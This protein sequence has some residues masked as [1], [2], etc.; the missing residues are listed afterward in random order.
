MNFRSGL[1]RDEFLRAGTILTVAGVLAGALGYVYQIVLVQMLPAAD[2][3]L[4]S[5]VMALFL[6]SSSPLSAISMIISKRVSTLLVLERLRE[7]STLFVNCYRYVFL[8]SLLFLFPLAIL[9]SDIQIYLKSPSIWPVFLYGVIVI[10]SAMITI[11]IAFLQAFKKFKTLGSMGVMGAVIKIIFSLVLV[12]LGLG[13]SGA[14]T[15]V[16]IASSI[17]W[18]F[19][20]YKIFEK[21]KALP[22]GDNQPQGAYEEKFLVRSFIPVLLANIAFAAMTQ[23]DMVLVNYFFDTDSSS[24]YAIASVLGKAILY[25]PSGM[26]FA[27]F[28][29]VAEN[30]ARKESSS[31]LFI[32]VMLATLLLCLTLS[33]I[34]F[35]FS[36][37]ILE[38]VFGIK[39]A[40]ASL[41]LRCFGFA[42]VPFA[43][44]LAAEHYLIAQGRVLFAWVFL[45][46]A[47]I[48]IVA[49]AHWHSDPLTVLG[50]VSATGVMTMIVGL[51]FLL[52]GYNVGLS[53]IPKRSN[54]K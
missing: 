51:F 49:I 40:E 25:I 43:V 42:M 15:G 30:V 10:L 46:L 34:Y 39:S 33:S 29:M 27:L 13:A 7:L 36:D 9:S 50:L 48:E 53:F 54:K 52:R 16:L 37:V 47:P 6:F 28:P 3:A 8:I 17:A 19:Y 22:I 38:V 44:T 14:I 18:V 26:V 5:A 32:K 12:V 2:F 41:L 4:F 11:N 20:S 1:F 45:A 24:H 21:F 31:H 35:I 23:L